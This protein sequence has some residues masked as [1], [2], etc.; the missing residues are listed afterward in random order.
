MTRRD[1]SPRRL[2]L[3]TATAFAVLLAA[4]GAKKETDAT[5]VAARVNDAE[6]TVHQ[7]NFRLQQER[8][9]PQDQMDAASRKILSRLID[10]ELAIQKATELKLDREPRTAQALEAARREVLARAYFEQVASSVAA[11]TEDAVRAYYDKNPDLFAQRKVYSLT[12]MNLAW[13]GD[14]RAALEEQLKAGKGVQD[15][16]AWLK[17]QELAFSARPLAVGAEALPLAIVPTLAQIKDGRGLLITDGKSQARLVFVNA[18]KPEPVAFD[19]AKPAITSFLANEARRKAIDANV[20]AMRTAAKLEFKG[21]FAD[22]AAEEP[23][24]ASSRSVDPSAVLTQASGVQVSL[25]AQEAASSVQIS[26]PGAASQAAGVQISLPG[27]A[28]QAGT[29]VTLPNSGE[30]V[31]VQLPGAA[32]AAAR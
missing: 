12:E 17:S 24:L 15:I 6:L 2:P 3:L 1:R 29:R 10:Q 13:P 11:P 31:R 23:T 26:L 4:C 9:L 21:K 5:Q 20:Q 16:A 19:K 27:A 30:G 14:K 32:S 7:I 18:S 8:N 28:S 22:M 25:P